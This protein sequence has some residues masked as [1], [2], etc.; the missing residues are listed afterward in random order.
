MAEVPAQPKIYHIT[1]IDNLDQILS[2]QKLWSDAWRLGQDLDCKIIGMS[3]IK[4]R[5]LKE[6]EVH[7][8]LGTTVGQYV[9]FYFCPRSIMLYIMYKGNHPNVTY[10]GGQGPILHLQADLNSTVQWANQ[11]GI[12][13]AFTD[14]NAGDLLANFYNDLSCLAQI[15]WAAV[16]ATDF[17]NMLISVGKQAEFLMYESFPW[18]LIEK[19]GVIS[20]QRKEQVL[21]KLE[22]TTIPLVS[23]E[24]TWYYG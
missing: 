1:H 8:H 10:R 22:H 16:A 14:R 2:N 9:P 17:R 13:W 19:I 18:K 6:L 20:E 24:K 5:R 4:L 12:P 15:N 21:H 11:C 3:D 23:V 7:C